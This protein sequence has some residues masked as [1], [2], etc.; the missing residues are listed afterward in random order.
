MAFFEPTQ[1]RIDYLIDMYSEGGFESAMITEKSDH[2]YYETEL[3]DIGPLYIMD[4]FGNAQIVAFEMFG[5]EM[6]IF[7]PLKVLT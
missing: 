6:F 7:P 2:H 4:D 3:Q 5:Q 1:E